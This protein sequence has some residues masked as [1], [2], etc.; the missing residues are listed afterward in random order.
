MAFKG[1]T[2]KHS[3]GIIDLRSD[4]VSKATPAMLAAMTSAEVGDDALG[5]DPPVRALEDYCAQLFDK[6]AALFNASGTMSN[7]VALKALVSHGAEIILDE[8]CHINFFESAPMAAL[9]NVVLNPCR[10]DRGLLRP[11]HIRERLGAKARANSSFAVPEAVV[12]ENT[13]NATGGTIFPLPDLWQLRYFCQ[14]NGIKLFMDGAR[15]LNACVAKE[16]SVQN[17]VRPVDA[18]AMSFTKGLGAPM[19]SIL[20]GSHAFIEEARRY[21]RWFGGTLHQAGYMAAAAHYALKNH[22][23]RLHED[24]VHAAVFAQMLGDTPFVRLYPVETNIVIFDIAEFDIPSS[25]FCDLCKDAGVLV[26]PWRP[27]EVRAVTCLN[28][29]LE[30]IQ[31]AATRILKVMNT[32]KGTSTF[33]PSLQQNGFLKRTA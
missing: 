23:E 4:T 27:T 31:T 2:G 10:A 24:H 8:S 28:Q 29:S 26:F 19:G 22:V 7:L 5:L 18:V 33:L 15:L 13:V 6:E 17:Y 20:V 11:D 30:D 32:L 21:R 1:Q 25:Q 16:T 12:V 3:S 9:A 14:Q